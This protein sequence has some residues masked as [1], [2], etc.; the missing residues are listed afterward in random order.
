MSRFWFIWPL[1]KLTFEL[2]SSVFTGWGHVL[3]Y[4]PVLVLEVADPLFELTNGLFSAPSIL[5]PTCAHKF[6]MNFVPDF[7]LC[8]I[9]STPNIAILRPPH[10]QQQPCFICSP[11]FS[12][13][14]SYSFHLKCWEDLLDHEGLLGSSDDKVAVAKLCSLQHFGRTAAVPPWVF[15]LHYME[16]TLYN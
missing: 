13:T 7:L 12:C 10:F 11:S 6:K 5:A 8:G 9:Q 3:S 16:R 14:C 4:C 1:K 2:F 15:N